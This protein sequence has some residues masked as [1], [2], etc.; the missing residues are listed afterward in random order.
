MKNKIAKFFAGKGY[1]I[2]LI[3]C[4]VAIGV[5]GYLYYRNTGDTLDPNDP[6]GGISVMN[7]TGDVGTQGTKPHDPALPTTPDPT[8]PSSTKPKVFKT[9]APVNGEHVMDY[10]MDCLGYNPTTRDW[11]THDGVD[12]AAEEGTKVCAA[13]DGTVYTVYTDEM[14]GT[15]VVI[16]HENGYVTTYA[17]L[18]QQVTVKAGDSVKLGDTIGYV[19]SSALLECAIGDHVHF[20][21]TCNGETM[22]P[23]AFLNLG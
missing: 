14:M 1:Y 15:T 2:A 8:K 22:D 3:L 9:E 20:S 11:R 19:G 4:A 16:R 17:S 23:E 18:A 6:S 12:I 5:T 7:P 13:A 10:C 21:V